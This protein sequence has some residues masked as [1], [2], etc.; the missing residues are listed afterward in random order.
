MIYDVQ[1]WQY[2]RFVKSKLVYQRM[3][4]VLEKAFPGN[5]VGIHPATKKDANNY[6]DL[7]RNCDRVIHFFVCYL[8]SEPEVLDES[9]FE[10]GECLCEMLFDLQRL[11]LCLPE[12][13]D[14]REEN[15]EKKAWEEGL[16]LVRR[17]SIRFHLV[18][19]YA[20]LVG[21]AQVS[22]RKFVTETM[23]AGVNLSLRKKKA[24]LQ[25]FKKVMSRQNEKIRKMLRHEEHNTEILFRVNKAAMKKQK[26]KEFLSGDPSMQYVRHCDFCEEYMETWKGCPCKTAWYCDAACQA[27]HWKCHRKVCS[28]AD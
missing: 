2:A 4:K 16:I 13:N 11:P 8:A 7:Q 15:P 25:M 18:T 9:H 17:P 10:I 23:M 1:S 12:E 28:F 27:K 3:N 21:D 20:G 5:M 22:K 24:L 14:F 6:E 26:A 19:N